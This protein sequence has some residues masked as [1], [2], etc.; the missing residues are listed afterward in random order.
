MFIL[1]GRRPARPVYGAKCVVEPDTRTWGII[2]SCWSQ[3]R[4]E[5]PT[6]EDICQDWWLA[7]TPTA[8][9][10]LDADAKLPGGLH[11]PDIGAQ[12]EATLRAVWEDHV[13]ATRN[14]AHRFQ[15]L[16]GPRVSRCGYCG[17]RMWGSRYHCQDCSISIHPRCSYLCVQPC[18]KAS[19]SGAMWG[20]A[21]TCGF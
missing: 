16:S 20:I 6:M 1:Q 15:Q 5:R 7:S 11:Q 8:A 18:G 14:L 2:T 12:D 10:A 3:E 4:E 17:D 13:T 21:C 19:N 9:R